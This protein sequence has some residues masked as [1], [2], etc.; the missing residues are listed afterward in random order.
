MRSRAPCTSRGTTPPLCSRWRRRAARRRRRRAARLESKVGKGELLH[1]HKVVGQG[2]ATLA[3]PRLD[4]RSPTAFKVQGPVRARVRACVRVRVRACVR[5][6]CVRACVRA[7]AARARVCVWGGSTLL[8][9]R[10]SDTSR[11]SRPR[12]RCPP[13]AGTSSSPRSGRAPVHRTREEALLT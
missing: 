7:R 6:A 10:P 8:E 2:G 13:R 1:T 5:A 11:R 12:T 4:D 3:S 9:S